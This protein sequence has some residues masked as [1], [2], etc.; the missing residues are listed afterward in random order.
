[1]GPSLW[2]GRELHHNRLNLI[3]PHGCGWGT[4]PRD[5]PR[6]DEQRAY[7]A[8]VS[9]TRQGKLTAPGLI[10]PIVALE[11]GP[12][13]FHLIKNEPDKVIKYAVRF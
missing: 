11:D 10:Q 13:I 12:K 2:L 3:V 8:I 5:Y 1:M 4:P 7:K 6:W 9:M